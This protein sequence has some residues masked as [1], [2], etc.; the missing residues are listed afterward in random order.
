MIQA[1]FE[2][3]Q[4]GIIPVLV[5][6]GEVL[7]I[8]L[9]LGLSEADLFSINIPSGAT[10]EARICVL[11]PKENL[12][13]LYASVFEGNPAAIFHWKETTNGYQQ[14]MGVWLLP[15]RPL[16]IVGGGSGVAIVEAVDKRWWWKQSQS[17]EL[18]DAAF[19]AYLY[20]SD[21]RWLVED[22]GNQSPPAPLFY[23]TYIRDLLQVQIEGFDIPAGFSPSV[24]LSSRF[25]DYVFTPECSLAMALDIILS[26]CGW[27]LQWDCGSQQ[28]TL[29]EVGND[30]NILEGFMDATKR[31][32]RGGQEAASQD[33]QP[34]DELTVVWFGNSNW[35]K[36]AFP[37]LVTASFP[38]RTV[39]GKT[40]YDNTLGV[41]DVG[42]SNFSYQKEFG[43]E[44]DLVTDRERSDAGLRILKEP[45]SLVASNT[46]AF[47]NAVYN[48]NLAPTAGASVGVGWNYDGFVTAIMTVFEART[49]VMHGRTMWAGW[50]NI[51]MGSY[52]CTMLR[53]GLTRSK[54]EWLPVALTVC[55][56]DDWILGADGIP[57]SNPKEIIASKGMIHA[58]KLNN[59]VTQMDV[60]P[61]SCRV[62]PAKI[63]GHEQFSTWKWG[64]SFVEVEPIVLDVP[65]SPISPMT[66]SIGNWA[67]T[68]TT[69]KARN[70]IEDSNVY[71]SAGSASN[72]IAPGV[73][74]SDYTNAAIEPIAIRTNTVV[75]MVEQFPSSKENYTLDADMPPRFWFVMPN[76]I[77][78]V[79]QEQQQ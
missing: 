7:D 1:W 6:D 60:A 53:Y 3:S 14:S 26:A 51:P 16:Y 64:Y 31:A 22:R 56:K 66:V 24:T 11:V 35:Q 17:N 47:F 54:G 44:N 48:T 30:I 50:A 59:G 29:V 41:A 15:P 67:R 57:T 78:V 8:A 23:V 13:A 36:N 62:F 74:Q 61:P 58:R 28:L 73:L 42:V 27:M 25:A 70:L 32:F 19:R 45:R 18:N 20:S 52:R 4:A 76:A 49:T 79:C 71:I 72:I 75:M 40:H 39:E 46:V 33:S 77:K 34:A 10:R 63:T 55:E 38:F 37:S 43:W 21:G 5:P 12:N 68:S 69:F 65:V 2:T 9:S